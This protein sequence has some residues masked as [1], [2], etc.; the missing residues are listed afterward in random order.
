MILVPDAGCESGYS[1]NLRWE[2]NDI[3]VT[4]V[5][6]SAWHS[7][8]PLS[9]RTPLTTVN[10]MVDSMYSQALYLFST[11]LKL[12]L[13]LTRLF[14]GELPLYVISTGEDPGRLTI[15]VSCGCCRAVRTVQ[16]YDRLS[17][18]Q[19]VVPCITGSITFN[20][21]LPASDMYWMYWTSYYS[22]EVV[23]GAYPAMKHFEALN[24]IGVTI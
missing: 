4:V 15:H 11:W 8:V 21:M 5:K 19:S 1:V 17:P 22:Y 9:N 12:A 2:S 23:R 7:K 24:S 14:S 18:G 10:M 16:V 3:I 6:F 13:C 20:L